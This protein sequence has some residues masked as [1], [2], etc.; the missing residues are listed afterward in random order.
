MKTD[1]PTFE[2]MSKAE[3]KKYFEEN[4][5]SA[6]IMNEKLQQI[7]DLSDVGTDR[8]KSNAMIALAQIDK[9]ISAHHDDLIVKVN[10]IKAL[11]EFSGIKSNKIEEI[12][13]NENLF[14]LLHKI[15]TEGNKVSFNSYA[16]T[17]QD[18]KGLIIVEANGEGFEDTIRNGIK[19]FLIKRGK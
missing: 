7:I 1:T 3:A 15:E 10:L 19:E 14:P 11:K 18:E 12:L 9:V 5:V 16:L 13:T 17:I 4:G 6:R 2:K 8:D